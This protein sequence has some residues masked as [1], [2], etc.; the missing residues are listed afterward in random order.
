VEK[1]KLIHH[2]KTAQVEELLVQLQQRELGKA[3]QV[4]SIES[5]VESAHT[6][7]A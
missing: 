7:S 4:K 3:V 6:F 2:S 5:R 1:C